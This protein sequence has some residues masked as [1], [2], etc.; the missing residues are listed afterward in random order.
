MNNQKEKQ[1][2]LLANNIWL[3][4]LFSHTF[5]TLKL[6]RLGGFISLHGDFKLN[7]VYKIMFLIF[8]ISNLVTLVYVRQKRV[9]VC[10]EHVK[11][12][13]EGFLA[14]AFVV[15]ALFAGYSLLHMFFDFKSFDF[16]G[17]IQVMMIPLFIPFVMVRMYFPKD[18]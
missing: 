18:S 2:Y 8:I 11:H 5:L 17:T 16:I 3:L 15:I 10:I 14:F 4:V 6:N 13:T 7:I 1:L 12:M 9:D